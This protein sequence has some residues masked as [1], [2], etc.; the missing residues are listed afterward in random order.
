MPAPPGWKGGTICHHL[1]QEGD[2]MGQRS[3][4]GAAR[5]N[6]AFRQ[7]VA[8]WQAKGFSAEEAYRRASVRSQ[9]LSL[10]PAPGQKVS[11]DEPIE[12]REPDEAKTCLAPDDAVPLCALWPASAAA[13]PKVCAAE[14][15]M[16]QK[17]HG[18]DALQ[19]VVCAAVVLGAS[20]L[21]VT[22][23]VTVFGQ[24]WEG[25]LKAILLEVGI[26]GLSVY[27][28][29]GLVQFLVSRGGALLLVA[30]SLL[31]LHAG[32]KNDASQAVAAATSSSAEVAEL[33]KERL[34]LEAL[35]ETLPRE[36]VTRRETI[37]RLL[38]E[39]SARSQGARIRSQES[40]SVQAS[41]RLYTVEAL[42][43]AALMFLNISF[44]HGLIR[45]V[46]SSALEDHTPR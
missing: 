4:D 17:S 24:T 32:V 21:L 26:V 36:H 44:A 42:M 33:R 34:H 12:S 35:L 6:K 7:R 2:D 19:V 28:P 41:E 1:K 20:T 46:R 14:N 22:S 23:S 11:R 18:T 40:V 8:Y 30:L 29:A 39:N 37:I 43:R 25:W 45:R 38:S 13:M 15:R 31:V 16:P 27:R 10:A 9:I 5:Q 3:I